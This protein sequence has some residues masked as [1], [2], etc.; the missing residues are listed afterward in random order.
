M[1]QLGWQGLLRYA[2]QECAARQLA[3]GAKQPLPHTL[4]RKRKDASL[5][6]LQ[7]SLSCQQGFL[8]LG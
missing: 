7:A 3:T 6:T 2:T 4:A 8:T 1:W 5:L